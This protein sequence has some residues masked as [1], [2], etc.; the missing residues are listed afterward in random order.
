MVSKDICPESRD[1]SDSYYDSL[2]G[3]CSLL[4]TI[5]QTLFHGSADNGTGDIAGSTYSTELNNAYLRAY[6]YNIT[7]MPSVQRANITDSLVRKDMAKMI[8]NF[9]INVLGKNVSTGST[10]CSFSDISS[11]SKDTQYYIVTS[12]RLG[13]MGLESD[14][15]TVK[16]TFDPSAVIDR[17][18]FGTVLSRLIRTGKYNGGNPYYTKHLTALKANKIMTKI[19]TPSQDEI[20]G[21]VML[22]MM[23]AAQ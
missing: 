11:L 3:K 16:K 7:T 18:Q 10:S 13:L 1:C 14:G 12:C 22:M 23:R 2:C 20:R 19:D 6:K 9:A 15:I 17:G 5:S 4:T 8:S 21:Y